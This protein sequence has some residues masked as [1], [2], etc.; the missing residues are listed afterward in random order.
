MSEE[1]GFSEFFIMRTCVLTALF[2][3]VIDSHHFIFDS[4]CIYYLRNTVMTLVKFGAFNR[5]F[6]SVPYKQCDCML[7]HHS[8]KLT[9]K[10]TARHIKLHF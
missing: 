6:L 1:M 7:R 3:F 5:L 9:L 10:P 8:L 2:F 4:F